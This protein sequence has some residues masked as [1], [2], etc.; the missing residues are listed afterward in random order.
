[1]AFGLTFDVYIRSI[2]DWRIRTSGTAVC[3]LSSES[4]RFE[5][6]ECRENYD[7]E[8]GYEW[9]EVYL[10]G[11]LSDAMDLKVGRQIVAWGRSDILQVVDILNP[12][13]FKEPGITAVE[14]L[15]L[16][17]GMVRLDYYSENWSVSGI[18]ILERRFADLPAYVM[19]APLKSIRL[20]DDTPS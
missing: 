6:E 1:M 17:A 5:D 18:S 9:N 16:P 3:N 11:R 15:R 14:D 4:R 19:E 8:V 20:D 7:V 13:D 12:R 10:Q 2:G